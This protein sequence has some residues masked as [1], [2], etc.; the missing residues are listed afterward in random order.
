MT[1]TPP[2]P[3]SVVEPVARVA[4]GQMRRAFDSALDRL[5]EAWN[6]IR[7]ERGLSSDQ[8]IDLIGV[9][10]GEDMSDDYKDWL[11]S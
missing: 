5:F 8:M 2:F 6:E 10:Y 11:A 9:R 4:Y 7:Q 1:E 3:D